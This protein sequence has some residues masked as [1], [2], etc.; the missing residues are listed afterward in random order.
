MAA[1]S[2]KAKPLDGFT[3]ETQASNLLVKPELL[4]QISNR[5]IFDRCLKHAANHRAPGPD[6]VPNEVLKTCAG[7]P[8]GGDT[9]A[10]YHH[11]Y[12]PENTSEL[13][14]VHDGAALQEGGP[15]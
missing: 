9:L 12:H 7:T 10:V 13:V 2:R 14:A 8:Q 6:T 5:E 4:G 11:I 15:P 1:T 3:L